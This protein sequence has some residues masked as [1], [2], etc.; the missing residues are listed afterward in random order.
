[1]SCDL[2]GARYLSL[3]HGPQ[4]QLLRDTVAVDELR[5]ALELVIFGFQNLHIEVLQ[6]CS[7]EL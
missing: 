1:M 5:D 3:L 2:N 6:Q 7:H 4:C